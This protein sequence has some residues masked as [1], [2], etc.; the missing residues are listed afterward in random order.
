MKLVTVD[1]VRGWYDKSD[2]LTHFL[3]SIGRKRL[4]SEYIE[5]V[6]GVPLHLAFT[7]DKLR[8]ER[9]DVGVDALDSIFF[10]SLCKGLFLPLSSMPRERAAQVFGLDAPD[11]PDTAGRQA[12]IASFLEKSIGLTFSQKIACILGDAFF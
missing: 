11:P 7:A 12:L 4:D 8:T 2:S 3:E 9:G 10:D 5:A 6:L 1:D